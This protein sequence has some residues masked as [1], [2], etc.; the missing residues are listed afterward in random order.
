MIGS[1]AKSDNPRRRGGVYVALSKQKKIFFKFSW[2]VIN[3][4]R[5]NMLQ[6]PD[7]RHFVRIWIL[8]SVPPTNG[9][10]SGSDSNLHKIVVPS[11]YFWLL[12]FE[13][14]FTSLS[15]IEISGL[16]LK[17]PPKKT[18]KPT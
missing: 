15:Q 5:F 14:T 2:L 10:G 12:F 16:A 3:S 18:K 17:N 6:F 1:V 4:T 9:S 8:G 7:P 13:G 11:K